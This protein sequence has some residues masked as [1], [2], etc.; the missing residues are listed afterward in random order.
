MDKATIQA[1]L[2]AQTQAGANDAILA[3]LRKLLGIEKEA[4]A[5]PAVPGMTRDEFGA[6]VRAEKQAAGKESSSRA[7]E[8]LSHLEKQIDSVQ[9]Q[10]TGALA[11]G[12]FSS[13]LEFS[14]EPFAPAV[15]DLTLQKEQVVKALFKA[16]IRDQVTTQQVLKGLG[17]DDNL[18]QGTRHVDTAVWADD[19][20]PELVN[21]FDVEGHSSTE[22]SA[23][24]IELDSDGVPKP[25]LSAWT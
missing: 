18:G 5:E 4:P 3:P 7:A 21:P 9:A 2:D 16:G 12:N 11:D 1:E 19:L 23:H 8:R 6:Y 25:D 20:S 24:R 22:K 14:V 15:T 17:L 10:V 13:D